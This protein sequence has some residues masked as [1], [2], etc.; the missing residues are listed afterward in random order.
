MLVI[1]IVLSCGEL[2]ARILG[3]TAF[4]NTD[5][6]VEVSP[7]GWLKGS[8]TYGIELSPGS[9][10]VTLNDSVT[11]TTKHN[12]D[13]T[14]FVPDVPD[15]GVHIGFFGCSF[16]YGYGVDGDESFVAILQSEYPEYQVS[17][18]GVPGW[19]E[20]QAGLR[21]SE[22]IRKGMQPEAVVLVYSEVHR[23]RNYLANSYRKAL[24][25]G[26][27]RSNTD[28]EN[29]MKN[30]R[31]PFIRQGHT[32]Y[33]K[34]EHLYSNWMLRE[35]SALVHALQSSTEKKPDEEEIDG[36]TRSTMEQFASICK[37]NG[38]RCF[39]VNLDDL[40]FEKRFGNCAKKFDQCIHVGFDFTRNEWT[41][42]PYDLH[43]N[44]KGHRIIANSLHSLFYRLH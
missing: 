42:H 44:A 37:K 24:T 43:P 16:T 41:N 5:Y 22:L 18:Y 33:E 17:N 23:E 32:E 39:L 6:K 10:K 25:M 3:W 38:I 15:S 13:G 28:V 21:L 35:H 36:S 31:F 34:W 29:Q 7:K 2:T 8:K 11:F 30:A 9:Y 4:Y 14:R 26:F 12:S 40:D 1:L 27:N 19:G 20:V